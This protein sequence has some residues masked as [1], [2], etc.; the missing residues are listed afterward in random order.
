M[1]G[2]IGRTD[3]VWRQSVR[4]ELSVC[5]GR[6]TATVLLDLRKCYEYVQ[7]MELVAGG[8]AHGYPLWLLRLTLSSYTWT[9]HIKHGSLIHGGVHARR[10]IIAGCATAT[11]ELKAYMYTTLSSLKVSHPEANIEVYIDNLPAE[12]HADKDDA[13]V[14]LMTD[15]IHDLRKTF[16]ARLGLEVAEGKTCVVA[17][18]EATAKRIAKLVGNNDAANYQARHLGIDYTAGKPTKQQ[19]PNVRNQRLANAKA[20]TA[21][22]K[23]KLDQPNQRTVFFTGTLPGLTYGAE[24]TGPQDAVVKWVRSTAVATIPGG[25][26]GHADTI[27]TLFPERDAARGMII[28]A[29]YRY[30]QEIWNASLN[31]RQFP[32]AVRMVDPKCIPQPVLVNGMLNVLKKHGLAQP[33]AAMEATRTGRVTLSNVLGPCGQPSPNGVVVATE[34]QDADGP[35]REGSAQGPHG[36]SAPGTIT[37]LGKGSQENTPSA[38]RLC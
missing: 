32:A 8:L 26:K 37:S 4:A 31:H 24:V 15:V 9:R 6:S 23:T 36:P 34:A 28:A 3:I 20:K 30:S 29:L 16:A 35:S 11:A 17:Y 10:G 21:R 22:A 13:L 5:E 27:F 19:A 25:G 33:K 12:V 7:H 14:E 2:T 18:T 1:G 38:R